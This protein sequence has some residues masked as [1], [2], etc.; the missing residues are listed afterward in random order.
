[1]KE[2]EKEKRGGSLHASDKP[3][4]L[5][6]LSG[7]KVGTIRLDAQMTQEAAEKKEKEIN[8]VIGVLE[9]SRRKVKLWLV[10]SGVTVIM[11]LLMVHYFAVMQYAV[12]TDLTVTQNEQTPSSVDFTHTVSNGGKICYY[13]DDT[14]LITFVKPESSSKLSWGWQPE[15]NTFK[16]VVRSRRFLFPKWNS[17]MFQIQKP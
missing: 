9:K 12:L 4:V 8:E 17:Y 6:L 16:I 11:L 5:K 1:M 10:V 14:Q 13:Y 15:S 3:K 7:S 2:E